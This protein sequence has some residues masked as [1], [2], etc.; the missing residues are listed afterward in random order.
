MRAEMLPVDEE[1][2]RVSASANWPSTLVDLERVMREG[3][4]GGELTAMPSLFRTVPRRGIKLRTGRIL[5]FVRADIV[6]G[7][8]GRDESWLR[9]WRGVVGG[10]GVSSIGKDDVGGVDPSEG[11]VSRLGGGELRPDLATASPWRRFVA[12][13][14]SSETAELQLAL[15]TERASPVRTGTAVTTGWAASPLK[16]WGT[17]ERP[18][19]RLIPRTDPSC[20]SADD[21]DGALDLTWRPGVAM[22]SAD[23]CTP[24]PF[25]PLRGCPTASP[26][27]ELE[28][29]AGT[30]RAGVRGRGVSFASVGGR[31]SLGFIGGLGSDDAPFAAASITAWAVRQDSRRLGSPILPISSDSAACIAAGV[32][33]PCLGG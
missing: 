5:S 13:W 14:S 26:C 10:S 17:G 25:G 4:C 6:G 9:V 11:V 31:F 8:F 27:L 12:R 18:D 22:S 16:T 33:R 3:E 23:S 21:G 2:G 7:V 20:E 15:D 1:V 30:R 29:V 24:F 32:Q 19:P 28:L